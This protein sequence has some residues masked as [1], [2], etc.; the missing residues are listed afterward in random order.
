MDVDINRFLD[1]GDFYD[2]EIEADDIAEL[3]NES[4]KTQL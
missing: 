1:E 2:P 4:G 3:H